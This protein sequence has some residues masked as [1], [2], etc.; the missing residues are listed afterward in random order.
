MNMTSRK[1]WVAVS[2][3]TV[4]AAAIAVLASACAPREQIYGW[5]GQDTPRLRDFPADF[6]PP[7]SSESGERVHG[8]GGQGGAVSHTPVIFVHGNTVNAGFWNSARAHFLREGYSADEL[9]AVGYGWNS[10]RAFDADDL[11]VPT[12]NAFVLEVQRY[13]SEHSHRPIYQ[14]DIIGHSLGVTLVRQW[15]KQENA[16]H[17]VRNFVGACGA[18]HGVWTARPDT[19]GQNRMVGFELFPGSPWLAQLNRGG[20]TPGPTRY[21]TLYDGTGWGDV[22][23]PK[24]SK[25]SSKLEGAKNLAYNVEHGTYYDHLE[26]PREPE[27]LDAMIEFFKQA[28]EPLPQ[29]EPPQLLREGNRLHADQPDATVHCAAGGNYPNA[30]TPGLAEVLLQGNVLLTCYAHSERSSLSSPLSRYKISTRP[31]RREP[32]TL[33]ATPAGG[34]FEN[35][36]TVK[37]SASDPDAFIVYTTSGSPP[38]SGSPL[39]QEP[40]YVPGPVT[41][42]AVAV[43]PDGSQSEP[44]K[45]DYD[46]SLELVEADRALL[47]QF[48]AG[49]PADYA[50]KRKTGN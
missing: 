38:T 34:A 25:D 8:F 46:I 40:I 22:L 28:H 43:A 18:N 37:L 50:G 27:T 1:N 23:F 21:M 24:W 49:A 45:L 36:Q 47:R 15:M 26:L 13:L 3:G 11:S 17:L 7:V 9:W 12:L 44:L 5:L 14:F 32:L 48:D 30:K 33:S 41:L 31:A 4:A 19:R 29:A 39:Y 10:V 42:T 2:A 6:T 20:E 35:P 16:Y